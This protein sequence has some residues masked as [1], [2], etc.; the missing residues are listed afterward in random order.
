MQVL[1]L[2]DFKKYFH[3]LDQPLS[4]P[5]EKKKKIANTKIGTTQEASSARV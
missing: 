4:L 1:A 2:L 3:L 5:I